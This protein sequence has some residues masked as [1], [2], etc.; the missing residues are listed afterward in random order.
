MALATVQAV[1]RTCQE[2]ATQLPKLVCAN[3]RP[4]FSVHAVKNTR[5]KME[6]RHY[7]CVDVNTL[8]G[9]KVLYWVDLT[10]TTEPSTKAFWIIHIPYVKD[11]CLITNTLIL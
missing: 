1:Y 4:P 9:F 5:R 6:D 7:I 8:F 10:C 2:W 11:A 3:K